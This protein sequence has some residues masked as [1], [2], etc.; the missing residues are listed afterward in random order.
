M[1]KANKKEKQQKG[2]RKYAAKTKYNIFIYLYKKETINID[3][4][5]EI[6]QTYS[7]I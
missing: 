3:D 6:P 7:K 2:L 5:T 4:D 1:K